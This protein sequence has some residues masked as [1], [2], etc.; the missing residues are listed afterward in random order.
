MRGRLPR[1]RPLVL[2]DGMPEIHF[3]LTSSCLA[4]GLVDRVREIFTS[5]VSRFFP[6]PVGSDRLRYLIEKGVREPEAREL[7]KRFYGVSPL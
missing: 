4:K 2:D 1:R 6:Q 3:Q 5:A 7:L